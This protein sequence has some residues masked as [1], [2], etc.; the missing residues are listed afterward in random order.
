MWKLSVLLFLSSLSLQAQDDL[1][2]AGAEER[3][4][5]G[6]YVRAAAILDSLEGGAVS[7]EFFLALGNARFE[8]GEPGRAILAYERG[9]RLRPGDRDLKNNLRYVRESAGITTPELPDFFL[10]QLWRRVGAWL[11][12]DVAYAL[13]LL[14]WWLAVGGV[15]WWFLRRQQMEEKR[16]FALLPGAGVCAVLCLTL[17][18]L[19][20]SRSAF[21]Q[22]TD[23]AVLVEDASL[24]VAPAEEGSVEAELLQG[25]KLR[26]TDRVNRY[27][28]VQLPDG[29]QGYVTRSEIEII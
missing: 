27:L 16:R 5:A 20:G 9:L 11:G 19:A 26:I 13:S 23:E 6:D 2:L 7:P 17:F 15:V 28:K 14:C 8:T 10:L 29:R 24:R 25:H 1:S 22:S 4:R 3:M 18:L 12:T 21:L